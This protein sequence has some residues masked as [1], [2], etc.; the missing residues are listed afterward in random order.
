MTKTRSSLDTC[1]QGQRTASRSE[2]LAGRGPKKATRSEAA[3]TGIT[4]QPWGG[5]RPLRKPWERRGGL[6]EARRARWP[7]LP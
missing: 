6:Q 5:G 4:K 7:A 3:G 2:G 1:G